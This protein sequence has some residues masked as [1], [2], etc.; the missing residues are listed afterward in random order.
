MT[1][2][3]AVVGAGAWGTALAAHAARLDHDVSV[4]AREP[5]VVA[6][7]GDRRENR[8]FLEGVSLPAGL[9]ASTDAAEVLGRADLVILVAPSAFLR[10]VTAAV[11]PHIPSGA[12]VTIA[13]KGI[14]NGTHRLMLD[15]VAETLGSRLDPGELT[16]L[17]GPSFAREVAMGLPTDVVVAS[18]SDAAATAV[19]GILHSPMF[20]VYTS[21]DPIGVE[22]GGALKNVLAVAAG[23]CDGLGLGTN[24]R[25]ALVTRGLSEMARLG[26]ALGGDPLTFMGLSGVGDL[27]LTTTGALSRN[28]TLGLK[29]AEGADPAVFLA[30]QRSV[31]EGYGTAKAAWELAQLHH[32]DVPITEQVY[33]VLHENVSLLSAMKSSSPGPRKTSSGAFRRNHCYIHHDPRCPRNS[34]PAPSST[35]STASSAA[36][37]PAGWARFTRARTSGSNGGSRSRSSTSTSPPLRSSPSGSTARRGPRSRSARPTSAR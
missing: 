29:V 2:R 3:I 9:H 20:R 8:T 5:E 7:I 33:R 23:A 26:V 28:R 27:I 31:A 15:V 13:T 21:R 22:V 25:A 30:S 11:G 35:V 36:L 16:V 10:A 32:V 37:A 12:L 18:K 1:E 34:S 4:W 19:A 24:A 14:E 6:D 17:S